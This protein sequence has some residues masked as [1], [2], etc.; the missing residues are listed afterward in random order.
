MSHLKPLIPI[1]IINPNTKADD[2]DERT[3]INDDLNMANYKIYNLKNPKD[4]YDAVTKYLLIQKFIILTVQ[5][6]SRIFLGI[7]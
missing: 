3:I 5:I 1:Q 6:S 2:F 4:D 7:D